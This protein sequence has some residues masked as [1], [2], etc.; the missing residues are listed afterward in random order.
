MDDETL[1]PLLM[2]DKETNES[3]FAQYQDNDDASNISS[4]DVDIINDMNDINIHSENEDDAIK[5]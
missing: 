5:P 3:S 2:I 4:S 1:T